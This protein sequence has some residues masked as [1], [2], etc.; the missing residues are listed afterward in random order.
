MTPRV[1][2]VLPVHNAETTIDEALRSVFEQSFKDFECIVVD[3]GSTDG[4]AARL[5]A[6]SDS[7]LRVV[8]NPHRGLVS[9]LRHGVVEARAPYIA[10]LDADDTW[11]SPDKLAQQVEYLDRHPDCVVVGT[12]F[13]LVRPDGSTLS[14]Q[15]PTEDRELRRNFLRHATLAHPTVVFRK[16]VYEAVGGYRE[17]FDLA[18]DFDLWFRMGRKGRLHVLPVV[19]LRY[20]TGQ[21]GRSDTRALRQCAAALMV[22]VV[23]LPHVATYPG[24]PV[25]LLRLLTQTL[26]LSAQRLRQ[27]RHSPRSI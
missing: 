7:R 9:A 6:W 4:T 19:G 15:P 10:R 21:G 27:W 11:E 14:V 16:S 25:S 1:S 12:W 18:E 13:T 17:R 3:D 24:L 22:A 2:V 23:N 26:A 8:H 5:D 20:A